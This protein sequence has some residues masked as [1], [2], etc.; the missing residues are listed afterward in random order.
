MTSVTR[1]SAA[2]L[3]TEWGT[4]LV[5]AYRG[6]GGHEHLA[7]VA[8]DP[9]DT[10]DAAEPVLVRVHSE[11]L[12]GDVLGSKRCDC[13]PQLQAALAAVQAAGR[14]VVVY[15]RGH[16]GRGIGLAAKIQAYRLQD[17]GLDT[18]DAN[19]EL[20]F[21]VDARDFADAAAILHDLGV[22]RVRLLSNNP[23]KVRSL[24]AHG[25]DVVE[26]VPALA[27]STAE[28]HAYLVTKRDRM[29]HIL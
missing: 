28:N 21:P 19:V 16:E 8:G 1:V 10:V 7:L 17:G 22:H 14:G 23:A 12:T 2:E 6:A 26:R 18:Y 20:G 24:A 13:G 5:V 9:V 15:L 4:F 29:G 25:I 3:P 27:G 11:C